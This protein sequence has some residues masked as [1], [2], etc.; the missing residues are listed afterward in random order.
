MPCPDPPSLQ[1]PTKTPPTVETNHLHLQ[2]LAE[3]TSAETDPIDFQDMAAK[4][5]TCP[6]IQRLITGGSSLKINF[7]VYQ[8]PRLAGDS[9]TGLWRPLV[10]LKH[11]RAVFQ[12]LHSIAHPGRLATRRLISS[13]FV[14]PGLSKDVTTWE[15]EC[16]ACQLVMSNQRFFKIVCFRFPTN[17]PKKIEHIRF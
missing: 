11:R 1:V 17:V 4:Q 16:A 6:E 12:H 8:D 7:Q 13:R 9:S 3:A 15:R 10:P 5:A 14:W 2:E